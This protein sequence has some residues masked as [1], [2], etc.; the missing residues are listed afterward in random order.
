MDGADPGLDRRGDRGRRSDLPGLPVVLAPL[1]GLALWLILIA[2][3][4]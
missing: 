4:L 2:L 3:L 1:A